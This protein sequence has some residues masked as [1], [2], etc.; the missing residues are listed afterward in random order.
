MTGA[1]EG[2]EPGVRPPIAD[3]DGQARAK[4]VATMARKIRTSWTMLF[5]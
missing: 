2:R 5:P 1:R 3:L 4:I